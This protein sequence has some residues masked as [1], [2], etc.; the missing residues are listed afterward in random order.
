MV[1]EM[2]KIFYF[3][4]T[5]I[6]LS[7]VVK[8]IQYI[9]VLPY[10][11]LEL[12]G[13]IILLTFYLYV[14]QFMHVIIHET[15]HFLFGRLSG[16]QL[17]SFRVFSLMWLK[18]DH[19]I[20]LKRYRL[21]GTAGQCLMAPP[22][23]QDDSFPFVLYHLGGCLMNLIISFLL[24][25]IIVIFSISN[26]FFIVFIIVG[27][28][29]SFINAIPISMDGFINDGYYVAILKKYPETLKAFWLPLKVYEMYGYNRRL[30][31]MPEEWFCY[32]F[33]QHLEICFVVEAMM[34]CYQ[35]LMD[36]H[37]FKQ[38]YAMIKYLNE[39]KLTQLQKNI[40]LCDSFYCE[41]IFGNDSKA[42]P[43]YQSLSIDFQ[44]NIQSYLVGLRT[45]SIYERW[46]EHHEKEA[47][48]IDQKLDTY[49]SSYP[50]RVEIEMQKD[51][52]Q[53]INSLRTI[54]FVD[55]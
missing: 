1:R 18:K 41:M 47:L 44:K 11:L 32:S 15:G 36:Q 10:S 29:M 28:W 23:I 51:L 5:L 38:A 9:M 2:K 31:D 40:L 49:Q 30:K 53:N 42:I 12:T 20:S 37:Q 54:D 17:I 4:L 39:Q 3:I 13:L 48:I 52:I 25:L 27:L 26:L 46:I 22:D 7:L 19:H 34:L 16:Y 50:Y 8:V 45:L 35:R 43:L 21:K 14:T 24:I 55:L 6:G 33:D